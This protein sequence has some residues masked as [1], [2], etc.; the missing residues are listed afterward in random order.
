MQCGEGYKQLSHGCTACA[1]NWYLQ[2]DGTCE[3]CPVS[4]GSGLSPLIRAILV[5]VGGGVAAFSGILI[6]AFVVARLVGGSVTGS[7]TRAVDLLV[8][9]VMLL[10]VLAQVG[11]T[12]APGL[13]PFIQGLFKVLAAL[14]FED[15][16]LPSA[17]WRMYPFTAKVLQ[18]AAAIALVCA[19]WAMHF[20][21]RR[22]RKR[23]KG[24]SKRSWCR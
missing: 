16:G 24:A 3:P 20:Q 2:L 4:T 12:A 11:R 23:Q 21:R 6:A 8:W 18:C 14:Q 1:A 10:Q 5:F 13:P 17:C 9:S 19:L 22:Y 15:V 7:L